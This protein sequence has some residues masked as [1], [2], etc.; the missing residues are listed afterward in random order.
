MSAPK[1]GVVSCSGECC[2]V[3]TISR[4]ATRFV[5]EKLR[6]DNTVTICLP[7]FSIGEKGERMFAKY[8]PTIAV[9]GCEKRCAK[10]AIEKY[11]G[12]TACSI[13][14]SDLVKKWGVKNRGPR[15]ELNEEGIEAASKVAEAIASAMD[16]IFTRGR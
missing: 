12:K 8:F 9:D 6:P 2:D 1:I 10:K 14:V 11:S 7:L 4:I 15:R 13:V 5:L 3:G 16:D